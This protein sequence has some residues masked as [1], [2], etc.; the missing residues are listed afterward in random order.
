MDETTLAITVFTLCYVIGLTG[1]ILPVVP[2]VP[3]IALG[4]LAAAMLTDF[5][6]ISLEQ[7]L[8]T[9]GLAVLAQVMEYVATMIGAR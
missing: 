5:Q 3:L 4:A 8:W 9:G 1:I 6:L 2:G 7:V